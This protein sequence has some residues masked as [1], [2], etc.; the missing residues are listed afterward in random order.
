MISRDLAYI[1][2][3]VG[4]RSSVVLDETK[5][6][7][8]ASRLESLARNERDDSVEALLR[9]LRSNPAE[10]LP[11]RVVEAL[12][13]NET[14]FFRD[15]ASFEALR[16]SVLPVLLGARA[17][18]RRLDIWSAGCSSGQEAYSIAM[19]LDQALPKRQGW[20]AHVLGTDLALGM[21]AR[22][23]RGQFSAAEV[24]RGLVPALL[25]KYFEPQGTAWGL[26][27]ELRPLTSFEPL[28]LMDSWSTLPAMDVIFL[29]N[30]LIYFADADRRKVLD[31]VRR[32]LR[33]DGVLFLGAGETTVGF[34]PAFLPVL[35]GRSY[36]YRLR[37]DCAV[38][39]GRD[40][41]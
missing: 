16:W 30:V 25:A 40:N 36:V 5:D 37:P 14:S 23:R 28:N 29:R 8:I 6:Y 39:E 35:I 34:D 10:G 3:L 31:R 27:D 24:G 18:T 26:R 15:P 7:L 33:P 9:R 2:R 13:T 38:R 32:L 12:I 11:E 4:E 21:I 19:T 41:R 1:R 20:K 17:R 22:A